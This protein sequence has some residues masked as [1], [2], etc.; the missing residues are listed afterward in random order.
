MYGTHGPTIFHIYIYHL[1]IVALERRVPAPRHVALERITVVAH[2]TRM[3]FD[4]IVEPV[5]MLIET[6]YAFKHLVAQRTRKRGIALVC[7]PMLA[8]R[9]WIFEHFAASLAFNRSRWWIWYEDGGGCRCDLGLAKDG[10]RQ[11]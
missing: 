8:Q 3:P 2:R 11:M 1:F 6:G 10:G 4:F 9:L 7:G 5:H